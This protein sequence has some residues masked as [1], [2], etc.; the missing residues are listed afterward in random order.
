M[1]ISPPKRM[2]VFT[3]NSAFCGILWYLT[4]TNFF[5]PPPEVSS[6]TPHLNNMNTHNPPLRFLEAKWP[7]GGIIQVPW[8]PDKKY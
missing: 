4:P 6:P 8:L 7:H 5:I 1:D 3:L 2:P